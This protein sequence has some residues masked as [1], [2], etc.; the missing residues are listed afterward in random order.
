MEKLV[1]SNILVLLTLGFAVFLVFGN[2]VSGEFTQLDDR[3]AIVENPAIGQ[4]TIWIKTLNIYH[5]SSSLIYTLF[6]LNSM[7]FHLRSLLLHALNAYLVYILFAKLESKNVAF[8]SAVL[9]AIHP[10]VSEAVLWVSGAVYLYNAFFTLCILNLYVKFKQEH[11]Q[12]YL[13]F[14]YAL[15]ALYLIITT[16]PWAIVVPLL[17]LLID[18]YFFKL[19]YKTVLFY[20]LSFGIYF[21]TYIPGAYL[22]RD[23][24]IQT[25][26]APYLAPSLVFVKAEVLKR[27]VS[28]LIFPVVLS[29][30]SKGIVVTN[31]GNFLFSMIVIGGFVFLGAKA[32]RAKNS[33]AATFLFILAS[34]APSL[35]PVDISANGG[36]RYFYLG[37]A[38]F[39]L[40]LVLLVEKLPKNA[41]VPVLIMIGMLY[42][43]RTFVRTF[44]W[45][46]DKSLWIATQQASPNNYKS[47]INLGNVYLKENN[48]KLT[49]ENYKQAIKLNPTAVAALY[50]LGAVYLQ[51]GNMEAGKYYLEQ[52]LKYSPN[53]T[54]AQELLSKVNSN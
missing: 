10:A 14:S 40:L 12:S 5:I 15:Y 51:L 52:A 19:N 16:T 37:T 22:V 23:E 30:F 33:L 27:M 25:Y 6:G 18:Y 17:V 24:L 53:L 39:C 36:E 26:G 48:R 21:A 44:D 45:K 41:F 42:F 1:K 4:L 54:P 34:I 49:I 46:T 8:I 32:L 13:I 11:K 31:F 43:T 50:N 20:F 47:Y 2:A 38:F 3:V 35:A 7:A 9:F 29:V 28:L